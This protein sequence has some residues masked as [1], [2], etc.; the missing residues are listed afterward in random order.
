[1]QNGYIPIVVAGLNGLKSRYVEVVTPHLARSVIETVRA[2]PADLRRH[3]RAFAT[4]ADDQARAIP[5]ARSS[6]TPPLSQTLRAPETLEAVVRELTSAEIER[7]LPGDGALHLLA[8]LAAPHGTRRNAKA[9]LKS[10][11]SALPADLTYRLMPPWKGP[12]A[13]SAERLGLRALLA[14]RTIR[15]LEDDANQRPA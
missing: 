4:I 2:L 8:A 12:E 11:L 14:V 15:L 13:L 1:M 6:S 3:S 7:V 5:Y 10:A 9:V